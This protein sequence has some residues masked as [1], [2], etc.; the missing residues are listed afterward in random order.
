MQTRSVRRA[1]RDAGGDWQKAQFANLI[2]YVPS[3]T[4]YAR[5]RVRGKLIV[6][7][8]KTDLISVA[9]LRLADLEKEERQRAES[10]DVV[11]RGK[12]LVDDAIRIHLDRVNGDVSLKPRTRDYHAQQVKALLKSWP[13]LGS[14]EIR[15]WSKT[16]CLNW[17]GSFGARASASAFNH[18]AG[19]LESRSENC[20][21]SC[22]G[23]FGPGPR[24]RGRNIP[25]APRGFAPRARWV[26]G[27]PSTLG[28][29]NR[30]PA[31][32][33]DSL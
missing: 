13:G 31:E 19:I 22:C 30:T 12:V 23:G 27:S 24:R 21:G 17:A 7:S 2:R 16:D 1:A 26:R 4:Y 15:G 32:F 9:K 8:L 11:H 29:E 25:A 18:T 6:R 14:R 20:P 3:G 33:S 5:V 28:R 10:V